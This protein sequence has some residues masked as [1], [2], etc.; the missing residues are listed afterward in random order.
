MSVIEDRRPKCSDSYFR[1]SRAERASSAEHH[2]QSLFLP[3]QSRSARDSLLSFHVGWPMLSVRPSG[4]FIV[5]STPFPIVPTLPSRRS[6]AETMPQLQRFRQASNRLPRSHASQGLKV[7]TYLLPLRP[8][9]KLLPDDQSRQRYTMVYHQGRRTSPSL[10]LGIVLNTSND[11]APSDMWTNGCQSQTKST[12]SSG[13]RE[14][15][16]V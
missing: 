9:Q 16:G 14:G 10:H 6:T 12:K 7:S 3:P 11:L 2:Q 5:S 1:S 13:Q 8:L 4:S 15:G